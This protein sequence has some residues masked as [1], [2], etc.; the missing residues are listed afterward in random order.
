MSKKEEIW[1]TYTTKATVYESYTMK[2]PKSV[3]KKG[4]KALRKYI[5]KHD[6]KKGDYTETLVV[7]NRKLKK[8]SIEVEKII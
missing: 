1:V 6:M 4:N 8:D 2:V 5:W 7:K 3:V